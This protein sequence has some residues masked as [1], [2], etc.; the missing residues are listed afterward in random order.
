MKATR[1]LE[2]QHRIVKAI[3]R[4]L[5]SGRTSPAPLLRELANNLAALCARGANKSSGW[6]GPNHNSVEDALLLAFSLVSIG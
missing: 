6:R 1:L 2:K 3:F 5:E 4:K